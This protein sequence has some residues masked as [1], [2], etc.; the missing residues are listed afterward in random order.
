MQIRTALLAVL[1]MFCTT[2]FAQQQGNTQ[3]KG[4]INSALW[5]QITLKTDEAYKSNTQQSYDARL[6][7]NNEFMFVFQI[8]EPQLVLLLYGKEEFARVYVEPGDALHIDCQA[9]GMAKSMTFSGT[10]ATN[11][12]MLKNFR[13]KYPEV[14]SKF[15][16][17]QYKKGVL[18]YAVDPGIDEKMQ[19]MGQPSFTGE[20]NQWRQD[21]LGTLSAYQ[22]AYPDMTPR[23]VKYMRAEVDY[24]WAYNM[25]VYGH[26]FGIKHGV[27]SNYFDFTMEMLLND[28]ELVSNEK[29]RQYVKSFLNLKYDQGPKTEGNSYI[30]QYN[31]SKRMLQ[32]KT[33]AFFQSDIIVRGLRKNDLHVMLDSYNEFVSTTPYYDYSIPALDMFYEKNMYAN[34]SPAPQFSMIDINGNQV[35]LY[36]YLGRVVYLDFWATWCA[37]CIRKM[38]MT[39]VVKQQL[40]RSDVVFIHISL[41]RTRELWQ[42]AVFSRNIAGTNLFADAGMESAIIQTYN[43]KAIPEYFIIDKN[44]NFVRKPKQFNAVTIKETLEKLP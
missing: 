43:V 34:G 4:K 29:Y 28:D 12:Q 35:N 5:K 16:M 36:D 8:T 40:N 21:R 42:E 26:A 7:S 3:I 10:G 9:V 18:Y 14:A 19:R 39:E 20:M 41:E 23:F 44:G 15:A 37:P 30:G 22:N 2:A 38:E 6:N 25:L 31:L 1:L 17:K 24:D 32:G 11:N 27:M 13:E 33:Q